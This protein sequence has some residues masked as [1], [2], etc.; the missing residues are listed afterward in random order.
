MWGVYS[1]EVYSL[2]A[3]RNM[4][5]NDEGQMSEDEDQDILFGNK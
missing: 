1:M 3:S 2:W 5:Y 4:N